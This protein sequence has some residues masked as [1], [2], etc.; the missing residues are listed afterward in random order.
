MESRTGAKEARNEIRLKEMSIDGRL[1]G[2]T[3]KRNNIG[4]KEQNKR[5]EEQKNARHHERSLGLLIILILN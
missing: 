1:L 5:C 4:P 3:D 2:T